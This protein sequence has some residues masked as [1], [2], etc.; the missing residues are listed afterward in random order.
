MA[1]LKNAFTKLLISIFK[2]NDC[3]TNLLK[4]LA[5]VSDKEVPLLSHRSEAMITQNFK[6]SI[7]ALH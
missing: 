5:W 3:Y 2:S 1:F 4:H 6:I 7:G